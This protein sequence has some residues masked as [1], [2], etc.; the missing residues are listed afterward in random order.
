MSRPAWIS[1]LFL[2]LATVSFGQVTSS[3]IMGT[4]T[5]P[6]GAAI[7]GI[8]VQL[9]DEGTAATRT[10]E[11]TPEGIF[12]FNSVPAAQYSLKIEAQGFKART[13]SGIRL[14]SSE[15]RDLGRLVLV[16]GALTEEVSVTAQ[17]TAVQ[18]A[19]SEKGALV[20]SSQINNVALRGRDL[21]GLLQMIPGIQGVTGGE[22][23]GQSMQGTINA[24]GNSNYTVDGVTAMDTGSNRST[25]YTPN[26]DS[27]AEVRVLTSNFSAEYGRNVSGSVSVVTKGGTQEFHGTGWWNKRHEQW[28]ANS[29]GNNRQ[30]LPKSLY[31]YDVFGFSVGGPAYIPHKFNTDKR[32]VFFFFSQEYSRTKPSTTNSYY[33]MPTALEKQGDFS[34]TTNG[35]GSLLV[36]SDPLNLDSKGKPIPFA[37][38]KIAS[39][40]FSP[41]G[42]SVLNYFPDPNYTETRDLS[43]LY[44][45]NYFMGTS[46]P[47]PKRNDM[48]RVDLN[49]TSKFTA[50]GRYAN[51]TVPQVA[52]ANNYG[53]KDSTGQRSPAIL[54]HPNSGH[55]Y[56]IGGTYTISPTLVAEGMFGYT[57]RDWNYYYQ[58]E[59]QVL[60]AKTIPGLPHWYDE[61]TFTD[62]LFYRP[63]LPYIS[64][65]GGQMAGAPEIGPN[66]ASRVAN[67][68]PRTTNNYIYSF[69]G[70][71]SK[72]AGAHN[73]KA[74]VYIERTEKTQGQGG[75]YNGNMS[76]GSNTSSSLD[77]GSGF[78]NALLGNAT[79]YQEGTKTV[80]DPWFTNVEPYIQDNWRVTKRLTL[81]IGFR[82]YIATPY[83]DHNGTFSAFDPNR[84]S[85]QNAPR[86]YTYGTDSAGKK[87][88][89]DPLNPASVKP[90]QFLGLYVQDTS[91]KVIGDPAN[92]WKTAGKNEATYSTPLFHPSPRLGF[93][94]DVFGDG[95][96][97]IRGGIGLM[98]NRFDVNQVY[99]MSGLPPYSYIPQV[100]DVTL[101][102]L[103]SSQKALGPLST[104]TFLSGDQPTESN[105][106]ASFGIQ[107]NLGFGTVLDASWVG[108]FRRNV[109]TSYDYNHLG[110]FPYLNSANWQPG[111]TTQKANVFLYPL[112]GQGPLTSE[113]YSGSVNYNALQVTVNR[114]M[115]HGLSYGLAYTFQKTISNTTATYYMP[116]DRYRTKSGA[117]S[118]LVFN[119]VYEVPSLGRR[120]HSKLLG[121]VTNDWTLAGITTF[122]SGSWT[123]P[124]ISYSTTLPYGQA[125]GTPE[126]T[127]V[128]VV[129]DWKVADKT[130]YS[131][132][133]V[134]AF[135]PPAPCTTT[136]KSLD[137][138]GTGPSAF[139]LGPSWNNWDV[140]IGR[141]FPLGLGEKRTLMFR[142]EFLNIWNHTE[143]SSYG[144]S[145]SW[146]LATN[147]RIATGTGAY[148]GQLNAAR[149]PRRLS[150]TLRLEF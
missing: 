75:F 92:G 106:N 120:L 20:D 3:N 108:A 76:F 90:V 113:Q 22:T 14:A 132:F 13:E 133:N 8:K 144:T 121:A 46:L 141:R 125:G 91:G 94:Y 105:L 147:Q 137:C 78:A 62:P 93:A 111:T 72:V 112:Q 135:A 19:T 114:R 5:D 143:Y 40:R 55:G 24:G 82:A 60:L 16:I 28:N 29:W 74:G 136:Y 79:S 23:A 109:Q 123:S 104:A 56:S 77:T 97:A 115:S 26:M 118:L 89:V 100:Y 12:R 85:A 87:I 64:F 33:K 129:G 2:I 50:Y 17:A 68:N 61:S 31:R 107:R 99:L 53:I 116:A 69:T 140:N 27:I 65:S 39:T 124:S 70:S 21:F 96:T 122:S 34:Q 119:Y 145:T 101:S 6:T 32:R 52:L 73:I 103:A 134:N 37:G 36:V 63:Y 117:P 146:N 150:F 54:D 25:A 42:L 127:R 95:K 7:P 81:D 15:T 130:P 57:W 9:K 86:L 102:Q 43:N 51:D 4:V 11:T 49:L 83:I 149:E 71:L 67:A 58:D 84:W 66:D 139:M 110:L 35:T 128:N 59:A 98:W 126:A 47:N 148:Y 138:L 10:T 131:Q 41:L 38:N 18:T 1:A 88:S 44:T 45:R 30:G 142:G 80:Y 48:F